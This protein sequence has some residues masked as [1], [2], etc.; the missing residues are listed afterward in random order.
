[1]QDLTHFSKG[2]ESLNRILLMMEYNLSKTHS[3]NLL[4]LSEQLDSRMPFQVEKSG[5]VQGKPETL[6]PA[7]QRQQ[8]AIQSVTNYFASWDAHDWLD[9]ASMAALLIPEVGLLIS[10]TLDSYNAY[11]YQQEGLYFEAGLRFSLGLIPGVVLASK[12]PFVKKYGKEVAIKVLS[13]FS[14]AEKIFNGS[15]AA[16]KEEVEF[17]KQVEKLQPWLKTTATLEAVTQIMKIFLDRNTPLALFGRFF[18]LAYNNHKFFKFFTNLFAWSFLSDGIRWTY[19]KLVAGLGLEISDCP[20]NIYGFKKTCQIYGITFISFDDKLKVGTAED[21]DGTL[22]KFYYNPK[23]KIFESTVTKNIGN[24]PLPE[25]VANYVLNE[26]K[27]SGVNADS[28]AKATFNLI[29]SDS[30][31]SKHYKEE[32]SKN[33]QPQTNVKVPTPKPAKKINNFF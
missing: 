28:L 15:A 24:K 30:I 8:Q 33:L 17:I 20:N 32:I 9:L 14:R 6:V 21:L 19:P 23:H 13:K 10:F 7:L 27:N 18:W 22:Q 3:E 5:Y 29:G 31:I 25:D 1:M 11:L 16:T 4:V 2:I 26:I 12:I